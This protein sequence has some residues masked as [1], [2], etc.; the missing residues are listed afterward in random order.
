MP[1]D[2]KEDHPWIN[3]GLIAAIVFG[4]VMLFPSTKTIADDVQNE[5]PQGALRYLEHHPIHG[6]VFNDYGW[7]GYLIGADQPKNMIFID[8]RVDIYEFAGVLS[9]YL[10]IARLNADAFK[11][12]NKYNVQA[13]L[14]KQ[15]SALATALSAMPGWERVYR[16]DVSAVYARK[17]VRAAAAHAPSLP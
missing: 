10:S 17:P 11:L 14:I 8:S 9:D 15:D 3:A 2:A 5:Y 1:E 16:D 7:G 6:Q 4:M 12:L 13:C